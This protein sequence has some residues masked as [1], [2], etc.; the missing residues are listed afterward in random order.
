MYP[1]AD[2]QKVKIERVEIPLVMFILGLN[3]NELRTLPNT[4][5][6]NEIRYDTILYAYKQFERNVSYCLD[7]WHRFALRVHFSSGNYGV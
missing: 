2:G 3:F 6:L 4:N 1:L 7:P 5:D